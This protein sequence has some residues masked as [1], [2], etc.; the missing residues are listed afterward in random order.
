MTAVSDRAIS[1]VWF[2]AMS[3]WQNQKLP[4][5][6]LLTRLSI[7]RILALVNSKA[8]AGGEGCNMLAVEVENG[9]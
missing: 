5:S 4:K 2:D 3:A 8:E 6:G 7:L 9:A 1:A